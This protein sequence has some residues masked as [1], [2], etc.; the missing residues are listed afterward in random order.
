MYALESMERPFTRCVF[1]SDVLAYIFY[2][3]HIKNAHNITKVA[4]KDFPK[5]K[6][7]KHRLKRRLGSE[8][9]RVKDSLGYS[10]LKKMGGYIKHIHISEI[11]PEI[12]YKYTIFN[13]KY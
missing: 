13:N 7:G 10:L 4:G 2:D 1:L 12:F 9:N 3:T 8:K 6:V 5:I 11:Y